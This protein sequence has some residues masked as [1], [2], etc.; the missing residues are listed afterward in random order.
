ML[1]RWGEHSAYGWTEIDGQKT[2]RMI[3]YLN[4]FFLF[5]RIGHLIRAT[6][7]RKT[8]ENINKSKTS[9]SEN[10]HFTKIIKI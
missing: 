1:E 4:L 8:M 5:H 10:C 3:N 9:S 7:W 6:E 2:V